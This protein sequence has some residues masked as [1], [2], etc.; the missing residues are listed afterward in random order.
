MTYNIDQ[1]ISTHNK[2][3]EIRS[4]QRMAYRAS[5]LLHKNGLDAASFLLGPFAPAGFAAAEEHMSS[6][7]QKCM[8]MIDEL[9]SGEGLGTG[10]PSRLIAVHLLNTHPGRVNKQ[11]I[12]SWLERTRQD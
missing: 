12:E 11:A 10:E 3:E 5:S 6:E 4:I 9:F 2:C 7:R 8:K 1:L